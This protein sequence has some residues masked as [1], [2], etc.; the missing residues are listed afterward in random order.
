MSVERQSNATGVISQEW[1]RGRRRDGEVRPEGAF[2]A[3]CGIL[4]RRNGSKPMTSVGLPNVPPPSR[5]DTFRFSLYIW[6]FN[7]VM[8]RRVLIAIALSSD[9]GD[10]VNLARFEMVR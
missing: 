7:Y 6:S 1:R 8:T 5:R 2:S 9:R 3:T 10:A 4:Y